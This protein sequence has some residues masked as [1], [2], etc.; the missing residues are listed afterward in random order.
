MGRR[1]EDRNF[2]FKDLTMEENP[3][4]EEEAVRGRGE[5]GFFWDIE[6]VFGNGSNFFGVLDPFFGVFE[7]GRDVSEEFEGGDE[8]GVVRVVGEGVG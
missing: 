2:L 6:D 5:G 8:G 3:L 7:A 1:N 4:C